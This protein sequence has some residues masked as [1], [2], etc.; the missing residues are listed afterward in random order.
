VLIEL[1]RKSFVQRRDF[2]LKRMGAW[3]DTKGNST[4]D[5]DN[6][7][8]VNK[9]SETKNLSRRLAITSVPERPFLQ[10][11]TKLVGKTSIK[12]FEA[13]RSL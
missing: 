6:P 13:N 7:A 2:Q 1:E 4:Q 8:K 3:S 10:V 12:F 5:F 9:P 11:G